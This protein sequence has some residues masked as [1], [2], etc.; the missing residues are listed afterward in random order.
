MI[1]LQGVMAESQKDNVFVER[2]EPTKLQAAIEEN[3]R[4][5]ICIYP[6]G[7]QS[8]AIIGGNGLASNGL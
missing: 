3:G 7:T 4:G 2:G 5:I 6:A 8:S 1:V